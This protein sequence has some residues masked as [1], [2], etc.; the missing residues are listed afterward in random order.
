MKSFCKLIMLWNRSTAVIFLLDDS[1]VV[2]FLFYN[3]GY[4]NYGLTHTPVLP[5][6]LLHLNS[7]ME[8]REIAQW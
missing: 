5:E 1:E 2:V 3:V 7:H 8:A 4:L 6:H